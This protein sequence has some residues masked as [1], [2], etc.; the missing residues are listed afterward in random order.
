MYIFLQKLLRILLIVFVLAINPEVSNASPQSKSNYLKDTK[1]S[2]I[3]NAMTQGKAR[4]GYVEEQITQGW[5]QGADPLFYG[6]NDMGGIAGA[7]ALDATINMT[8]DFFDCLDLEIVGLCKNHGVV[9]GLKIEYRWP[10]QIVHTHG[11]FQNRYLPTQFYEALNNADYMESMYY[12][13][14]NNMLTPFLTNRAGFVSWQQTIARGHSI[15]T[16]SSV[17]STNTDLAIADKRQRYAT[18]SIGTA[19]H[20]EYSIIPTIA[21]LTW[22]VIANYIPILQYIRCTPPT[23]IPLPMTS[24]DPAWISFTRNPLMHAALFKD[25]ELQKDMMLYWAD[26]TACVRYNMNKN[27]GNIPFDMYNPEFSG[28]ANMTNPPLFTPMSDGDLKKYGGMCTVNWGTSLPITTMTSLNAHDVVHSGLNFLKALRLG[29]GIYL[30]YLRQSPFPKGA[31]S[32]PNAWKNQGGAAAFIGYYPVN[33]EKDRIQYTYHEKAPR[34]C[35]KIGD[36]AP[37]FDGSD[38][39]RMEGKHGLYSITHWKYFRC[40]MSF[41]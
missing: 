17:G 1:D 20:L 31:E 36:P 35:L 3:P 34:K 39:M 7:M 6:G 15:N 9:T 37:K 4:E 40:C 5:S 27:H 26:P 8:E 24:E 22:A 16:A 18:G 12:P 33:K 19:G 2:Y 32:N 13:I 41:F 23:Q 38:Q 25:I 11:F 29:W 30:S 21:Q 10:V 14:V 28:L